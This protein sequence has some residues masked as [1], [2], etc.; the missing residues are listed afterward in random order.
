[1]KKK[2]LTYIG[3]GI[4]AVGLAACG[5]KETAEP[6]STSTTEQKVVEQ[7]Q[8]NEVSD[9]EAKADVA[10]IK[11]EDLGPLL[12]QLTFSA[13]SESVEVFLNFP[14]NYAKGRESLYYHMT[15]DHEDTE[16][17]ALVGYLSDYAYSILLGEL[18]IS[19]YTLENVL[20]AHTELFVDSIDYN[21]A[22]N[23][24][25]F[26]ME[27]SEGELVDVNGTEMCKHTG[28]LT[29]SFKG[30]SVEHSVVGYTVP[31]SID[32]YV[33]FIVCSPDAEKAE[34]DAYFIAQTA[35]ETREFE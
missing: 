17:T 25:D 20:P 23:H 29:Y 35:R 13:E 21:Y 2:L 4:L 15:F 31:T 28:M 7:T 18:G 10:E 33:F 30:V 9:K 14:T 26:A 32:S 24:A 6:S 1:M 16:T 3:I 27:V 11:E 22:G 5:G 8:E 19:E 12:R 34:K